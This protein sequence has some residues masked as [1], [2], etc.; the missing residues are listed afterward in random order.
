MPRHVKARRTKAI[1]IRKLKA[2]DADEKVEQ[3]DEG[4]LK[5]L[6]H[7]H[8][9]P[10]IPRKLQP[11]LRKPL[12]TYYAS[13]KLRKGMRRHERELL[14][15]IRLRLDHHAKAF[16]GTKIHPI[17]VLAWLSAEEP[18]SVDFLLE[19]SSLL[20]EEPSGSDDEDTYKA[21]D[22]VLIE[23]LDGL[24]DKLAKSTIDNA[25][26]SEENMLLKVPKDYSMAQ[27]PH[28]VEGADDYDVMMDDLE[29][30]AES[31]E[32]QE[33][34]WSFRDSSLP[35]AAR[36][37]EKEHLG[38]DPVQV[39][40]KHAI[41]FEETGI[42]KVSTLDNA[43]HPIFCAE[44]FHGCPAAI[45]SALAP[46]M[47]LASLLLTHKSTASFWHT[48]KF[49]QRESAFRNHEWATWIRTAVPWSAEND[50]RW[51]AYLDEVSAQIHITFA[52]WP[53]EKDH[54]VWAYGTM[55]PIRDY[56]RGYLAPS[57]S[58]SLGWASPQPRKGG[59]LSPAATPTT[60][61]SGGYRPGRL[62][63]HMDFY[64][65]AKRL[66]LLRSPDPAQVLR[67]NLFVAVNLCHELAHYV[68]MGDPARVAVSEPFAGAKGSMGP[69]AYF[70]GCGWREMGAAF[71]TELFGAC[72]QPVSCR[73]DCLYG[74]CAYDHSG[75]GVGS[76][77]RAS[78]RSGGRSTPTSSARLGCAV[79]TFWTVPMAYIA[80]VQQKESWEVRNEQSDSEWLRIPRDG[81][82]AVRV[83]YF[84]LTVWKD[85]AED[86]I[87]DE[88][89]GRLT[90]FRRT[91]DGRIEKRLKSPP[92][93]DPTKIE[94]ALERSKSP[95]SNEVGDDDGDGGGDGDG[96]ENDNE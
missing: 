32:K 71:E 29:K 6:S 62:N 40:K 2:G 16:S 77:S 68:E 18:F 45:Y 33:R 95:L 19:N 44:N 63:L 78:S 17:T 41:Q 55:H 59:A 87:S 43:I 58:D 3:R 79:R 57:T 46:G 74:L 10:A 23:Q 67:F 34:T 81:A 25:P 15:A 96:D 64:T 72:V 14:H 38:F 22:P 94:K 65:T 31:Q 9:L 47:R 92:K 75:E 48:L 1:F 39:L 30:E 91:R 52:L 49:G 70:L 61:T 12:N 51:K 5:N 27:I 35:A 66:S 13:K 7:Q 28:L 42:S 93:T 20:L 76:S 83:P 82:E 69:E 88:K 21:V 85:E 90:P 73:T 36:L 53:T 56:K 84:D 54:G 86:P 80:R 11:V 60:T 4:P 26:T 24:L 37:R 89:D 50:Q 8:D